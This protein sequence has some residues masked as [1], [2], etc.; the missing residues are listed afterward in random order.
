VRARAP[1]KLQAAL[2]A[3]R[4]AAVTSGLQSVPV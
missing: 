3:C 2:V 1:D 4:F